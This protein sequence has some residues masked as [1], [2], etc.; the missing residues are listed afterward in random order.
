[1]S[2]DAISVDALRTLSPQARAARRATIAA[3]PP[4]EDQGCDEGPGPAMSVDAWRALSPAAR[5]ARAAALDAWE[6][7]QTATAERAE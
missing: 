1:M 2:T 5:A 7:R 6:K 3:M 4:E